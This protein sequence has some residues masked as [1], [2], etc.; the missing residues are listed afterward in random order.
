MIG[1]RDIRRELVAYPVCKDEQQEIVSLIDTAIE[2]MAAIE[3]ELHALDRLKR[4]L[5]QN[6]LTGQVRVRSEV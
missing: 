5:L 2:N 4:S 6:L 1:K 3:R